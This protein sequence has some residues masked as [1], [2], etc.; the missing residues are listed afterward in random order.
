MLSFHSRSFLDPTKHLLMTSQNTD[1]LAVSTFE[2]I[3]GVP[4]HL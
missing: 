3:Q 1:K 2:V 4:C